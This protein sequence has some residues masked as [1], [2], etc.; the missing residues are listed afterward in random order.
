MGLNM[1]YRCGISIVAFGIFIM[2]VT[3]CLSSKYQESS[4]AALEE[5]KMYVGEKERNQ[6]EYSQEAI[7]NWN[8]LWFEP[9][10]VRRYPRTINDNVQDV[11]EERDRKIRQLVDNAIKRTQSTDDH[12]GQTLE[13]RR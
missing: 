12:N 8:G 6:I 7:R 9:F 4:I 11:I 10:E 5:K 2:F 13:K 3:G 1:R